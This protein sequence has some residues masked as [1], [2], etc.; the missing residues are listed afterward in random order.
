MLAQGKASLQ[1]AH[2]SSEGQGKPLQTPIS[3][4]RKN[5]S[6]RALKTKLKSTAATSGMHWGKGLEIVQEQ[7]T[8]L[9]LGKGSTI[10][11]KNIYLNLRLSGK[12][13][14]KG[15]CAFLLNDV[16]EPHSCCSWDNLR[17]GICSLHQ[18]PCSESCVGLLQS[19][20][21]MVM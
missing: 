9:L 12:V 2:C 10:N 14:K 15:C 11:M 1:A 13:I 4:Q 7:E 16:T 21:L 18:Q 3:C 6:I 20:V 8:P 5:F 17:T 19:S